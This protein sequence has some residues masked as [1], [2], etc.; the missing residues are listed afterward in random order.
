M[1]NY[2]DSAIPEPT[3]LLG[4]QLKPLTIGHCL[5]L[6]RFDCQPVDSPE[7]LVFAVIICSHDHNKVIPLLEDPWYKWKMRLWRFRLGEVDWTEKIDQWGGYFK[8]HC[9]APLVVS[10][11]DSKGHE[12]SGT[13]FLQHLKV[14]LMS[15]LGYSLSDALNCVVTQG[16]WDM[17]CHA[18]IEGT[19]RIVDRDAVQESKAWLE[20]N[21]GEILEQ[22]QENTRKQ[23]EFANA[24]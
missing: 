3:V 5:L 24:S 21:K 12:D 11:T 1:A 4:R 2:I 9:E 7:S 14:Y 6:Q 18:E 15:K 17:Y 22:V 16:I 13:P 19:M 20:K 8:Q 10:T 23:K